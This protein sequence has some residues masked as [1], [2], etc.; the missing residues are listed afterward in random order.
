MA[1]P[2][3]EPSRPNPPSEPEPVAETYALQGDGG[4]H[5]GYGDPAPRRPEEPDRPL[6]ANS[7]PSAEDAARFVRAQ[8][9]EGRTTWR[10]VEQ[11]VQAGMTEAA[12]RAAVAAVPVE[13][14]QSPLIREAIARAHLPPPVPLM[15]PQTSGFNENGELDVFFGLLILAGAVGATW[16]SYAHA[17]ASPGAGVFVVHLGLFVAGLYRLL[18]GLS[19]R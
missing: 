3:P 2:V 16:W 11:L 17:V 9:A 15:F 13:T 12:A 10:I 14:E 6:P 18:L 1:S 8:R 7:A 19:K 5:P 4:R